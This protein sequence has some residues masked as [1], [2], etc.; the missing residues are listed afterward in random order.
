MGSAPNMSDPDTTPRVKNLDIQ[1]ASG[2]LKD[3]TAAKKRAE[4]FLRARTS[5]PSQRDFASVYSNAEYVAFYEFALGYPTEKV[6]QTFAEAAT[7]ALEVF[8]LR[9]TMECRVDQPGTKDY[10]LTNSRDCL[11]AICMALIAGKYTLA[12]Q[13][14]ELMWDPPKA[15]YI[16]TDSEVCTS[17]QQSLAYAV[18]HLIQNNLES[19][20]KEL[21]RIS[22]RKGEQQVAA[23]AKM[24]RG[25][26]QKSDALFHEGLLEL[27]F[28]HRKHIRREDGPQRFFSLEGAGLSAL[29]LRD[30]LVTK[31]ALPKDDYLPLEFL[32]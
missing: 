10:S 22:N 3:F 17:N 26:A 9:G 19:V 24:V 23:M 30:G 25:M 5:S 31:S 14:A 18:K 20:E 28:Y 8:H 15:T 29:A 27:L 13:L 11:K 32:C 21:Q 1:F 16:G 12:Q 7:A 2:R 4:E 6:R